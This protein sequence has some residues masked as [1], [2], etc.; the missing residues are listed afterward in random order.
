MNGLVLNKRLRVK[1]AMNERATDTKVSHLSI[2][3]EGRSFFYDSAESSNCY[4]LIFTPKC[5]WCQASHVD[6]GWF[7]LWLKMRIS[8]PIVSWKLTIVA[9]TDLTKTN[10][11]QICLLAMYRIKKIYNQIPNNWTNHSLWRVFICPRKLYYELPVRCWVSMR[12]YTQKP[13]QVCCFAFHA[14]QRW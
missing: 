9:R 11:V 1:M 8:I 6:K 3:C 7:F 14:L 2:L 4:F 5:I 13:P 12:F 10:T